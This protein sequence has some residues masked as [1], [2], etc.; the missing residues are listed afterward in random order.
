MREE[1]R[2]KRRDYKNLLKTK[3]KKDEENF[4]KKLQEVKRIN[5]AWP[6][7]N[8]QRARNRRIARGVTDEQL[9]E[10]FIQL[11]GGTTREPQTSPPIPSETT[12]GLDRKEVENALGKLKPRKAAGPDG[13]KAEAFITGRKLLVEPIM[14]ILNKCLKGEIIPS[15]FRKTR[16]F[17]IYKKGPRENPANYRGI[18][19]TD[20]IAKIWAQILA[21]RMQMVIMAWL[22]TMRS[23]PLCSRRSVRRVVS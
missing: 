2:A 9:A 12:A 11:L 6:F 23:D 10:H 20:V 18:A 17:P 14:Q 8:D 19:I 15:D 4:V 21:E 5:E 22:Q 1:Y 3:K 13:I 7:I 16:Y